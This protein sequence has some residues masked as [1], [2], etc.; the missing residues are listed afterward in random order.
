M[1]NRNSSHSTDKH[2]ISD[3]QYC[4]QAC[5]GFSRDELFA[6]RRGV[7]TLI[8][9]LVTEDEDRN[10]NVLYDHIVILLSS[11][12][13]RKVVVNSKDILELLV[14]LMARSE[15]LPNTLRCLVHAAAGQCFVML[16][17]SNDEHVRKYG[18]KLTHLLFAQRRL[19]NLKQLVKIKILEIATIH[20]SKT[21]RKTTSFLN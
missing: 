1:T 14:N 5:K 10:L 13:D 3:S 7:L 19:Y 18:L 9:T 15:R 12:R 11:V 21:K 6:M 16:L 2:G 17:G 20:C 8:E 4:S